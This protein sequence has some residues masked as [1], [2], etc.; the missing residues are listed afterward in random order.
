MNHKTSSFTPSG[1]TLIELVCVMAIIGLLT[2]FAMPV[3]QTAQARSQRQLAKIAL[4]KSAQ[5]LEQMATSQGSYPGHLPDSV[6]KTPELRYSL[7]LVGNGQSF[8]LTASPVGTQSQ[9]NCGALT[10]D[11]AGQRGSQNDVSSC[12]SK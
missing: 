3:Y 6:W 8:L 11:Q 10:L 4:M 7:S 5:W 1:F 12:W 2:A 9:D